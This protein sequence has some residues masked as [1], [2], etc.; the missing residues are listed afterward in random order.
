[1]DLKIDTTRDAEGSMITVGGDI[2]LYS[3]PNLRGVLLEEI[4]GPS[5]RVAVDLAGVRY[6][7]S[8]GVATLVEALRRAREVDTALIL[9]APSVKVMK[10]LEMTRLDSVFE[11]EPGP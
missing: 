7:D 6:M 8:S 10:V 2:D 4:S 9:V 5:A 3:S 1:M 11:V